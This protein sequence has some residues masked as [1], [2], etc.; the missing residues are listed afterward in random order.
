MQILPDDEFRRLIEAGY[1]STRIEFKSPFSWK[2]DESL[3]LRE[4]VIQTVLG[5][6]NTGDG[7]DIILGIETEDNKNIK[8]VGLDEGQLNSFSYDLLKGAVD[9]FA[10]PCVNFDISEGHYDNKR[11]IVIRVSEFEDIPIIC[12]RDGQ[13]KD[14]ILRRGD[15]YCRSQSGPPGTIRATETEMRE[16]LE[17][18][19]D[20]GMKK[21]TKRGYVPKETEDIKNLF[22]QQIKDLE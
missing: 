2:D 6:A 9:S 21:L 18:A 22:D 15:I 5:L 14:L 16:I 12:K 19:I 17:L 13:H 11:F 10:S 3:W 4:K 7:G 20:K 1:E 8:L